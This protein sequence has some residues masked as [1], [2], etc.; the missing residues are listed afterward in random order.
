MLLTWFFLIL[1]LIVIV[2]LLA[3]K[4]PAGAG[5]RP[6][7][8]TDLGA[9]T[10]PVILIVIDSLMDAPLRETIQAGK[11]PALKYLRDHG[12]YYPR[13]ISSFP[14]MSACIDTTLL[15]GMPP[16]RH[17]IFGLTYFHKQEGRVVNFGTGLK[18]TF[19]IGLKNVLKDGLLNLNQHFINKEVKTIHEE[20]AV[21]TASVNAIIMRGPHEQTLTVPWFATLLGLL[22]RTIAAKAPAFFSFG[23]MARL[24]RT[25]RPASGFFRYGFNDRYSSAELASL[26]QN[27]QLPL[28]TI[29]YFP[30]NDDAVH[31]KGPQE[32]KGIAKADV[33]LQ[34]VL[35][36]F[37]S[38]EEAIR[39]ATFI[40]I[41]DSGQTAMLPNKQEAYIDLTK[42]LHPFQI[43]P[44]KRKKPSARDQLVLCVNERMAYIYLIDETL[45]VEQVIHVLKEETRLDVIA[46]R[47][48]DWVYVV[49]GS[50]EGKLQ[51]KPGGGYTDTYGQAWE[52]SGDLSIL[53]IRIQEN[54]I[55][56]FGI[57]PDVLFR[58]CN[59]MDTG[60]RVIVVT[61]APGYELIGDSSPT[62]KGACHGSLHHLDSIVPMIVCGTDSSP[63]HF[64]IIDLKKWIIDMLSQKQ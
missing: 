51:F 21:P 33:E 26:I 60:E 47:E 20:L 24:F 64:R 40:V 35:S 62:H 18:E 37:G 15:T 31:K 1:A 56:E 38:W 45:T 48:Q 50:T 29:A 9:S 25:S 2:L 36:A 16:N 57:F 28:F 42:L 8:K 41:G 12:H 49:S 22:P 6:E 34:K 11:A 44:T 3:A 14:T 43:M 46:W 17:H 52:I 27:G 13:V 4:P 61:A 32:I 19:T 7:E 53:D 63:D 10:R 5:N 58:L 59:V 39:K 30:S 23:A 55:L 54:Q